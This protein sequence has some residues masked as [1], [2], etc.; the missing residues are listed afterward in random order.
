M[1][2]MY[3]YALIC[4][5]DGS[6]KYIGASKN[7]NRRVGDHISRAKNEPD[8]N[9][10]LTKWVCS[11]LS[12]NL[13]PRLKVLEVVDKKNWEDAEKRWIKQIGLEN[14]L[15]K[16]PGGVRGDNYK[17]LIDKNGE[18]VDKIIFKIDKELKRDFSETCE[19]LGI[20]M[21]DVLLSGIIE[22]IEE[23]K[24]NPKK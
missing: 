8:S 6:I 24:K 7:P 13:K 16:M 10:D 22:F 19:V 21:T 4:P 18:K 23:S 11:L 12:E 15:N 5:K 20:S 17:V 3:I 9:H 2:K 1:N 14:L